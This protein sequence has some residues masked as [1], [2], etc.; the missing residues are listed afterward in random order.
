MP[1]APVQT[2]LWFT[3]FVPLLI[4][5]VGLPLPLTIWVYWFFYPIKGKGGGQGSHYVGD[6]YL[7]NTIPQN[8]EYQH[9]FLL[10][11]VGWLITVGPRENLLG[12]YVNNIKESKS[13]SKLIKND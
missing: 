12:I 10:I 9:Y 1:N 7:L 8:P 2:Q 13:G 5:M 11:L 6:R 4:S 3:P